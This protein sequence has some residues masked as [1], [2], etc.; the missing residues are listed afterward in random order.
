MAKSKIEEYGYCS[1]TGVCFNPFGVKPEWAQRLAKKIRH[2]I[3][4]EQAEEA[5]F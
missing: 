4:I 2:G 5:L 1:K 3:T